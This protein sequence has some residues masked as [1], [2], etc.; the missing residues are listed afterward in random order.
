MEL[1]KNIGDEKLR[2][3]IFDYKELHQRDFVAKTNTRF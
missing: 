1:G 2:I 3:L